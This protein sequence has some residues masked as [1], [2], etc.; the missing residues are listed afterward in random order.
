LPA[1]EIDIAFV[2]LA[3]RPSWRDMTKRVNGF[4]LGAALL[5]AG[6]GAVLCRFSL[7]GERAMQ[8]SDAEFDR[9]RLR[10]S[11]LFARR[12][13]GLYAPGL[14]HVERADARLDAIAV[15]A[16]SSHREELAIV[17]W[18]A[19]RSTERQRRW[20]IMQP[21][22]RAR[23]ADWRLAV[24]LVNASDQGSLAEQQQSR[25]LLLELENHARGSATWSL[26]RPFCLCVVV[27]GL[28][29]THRGYRRGKW[30]RLWFYPGLVLT[31][32]GTI[33]WAILLQL[34]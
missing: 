18:Q 30:Q 9:G 34:A 22:A 11:L 16:E 24:L 4:V 29:V 12:A 8:R 17:A 27:L 26:A 6:L 5:V 2:D 14:S 13:A 7:E 10:E 31:G 21:S 15:G 3:D 33:A 23:R 1:R 28:L 19:I 25:R 32:I 20:A